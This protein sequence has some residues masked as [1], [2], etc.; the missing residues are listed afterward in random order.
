MTV[1][2]AL[3]FAAG[4][5]KRMRPLTD[6]TPKPLL[7][8][9]G[10]HLI[11]YHIEKLVGCG[12][13]ELVINT[14][15]LAHRLVEELGDGHQFGARIQWSY[16]PNILDTGGGMRNAL[17]LLEDENE[18]AFL[19]INAD[20]WTDYPL[21]QLKDIELAEEAAHLVM[22]P[23]P[24]QHPEGD[25]GLDSQGRLDNTTLPGRTYAGIGLFTPGFIRR[26]GADRPAFPLREALQAAIACGKVTAELYQGDWED[27]GTPERL[28]EL[29]ARVNN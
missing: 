5:G 25:F 14:H 22:V 23:N 28:D 3:I 27:V 2:R 19:V 7:E 4:L 18:D 29:N 15:W 8:V 1:R 16:E 21:S 9:A 20:V 17:P 13:C 24:V 10:K 26:F 6:E 12:I 11:Q